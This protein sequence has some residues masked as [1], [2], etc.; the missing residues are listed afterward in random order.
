MNLQVIPYNAQ[1]ELSPR[2]LVI[3]G[4]TG[5]HRKD[6]EKH[7]EEL[8]KHGIPVPDSVPSFYLLSPDLITFEQ[9]ITVSSPYTS[10]EVEPV[11]ICSEGR[12]YLTVGSDHTD[13]NLERESI[14]AS[15]ASC[16]K[17]LASQ[18]WLYED[19]A[20][21]SDEISIH[22]WVYLEGKK[23]PY[24]Q[25]KLSSLLPI[26]EIVSEL[27]KKLAAKLVNAVVFLGTIPL[28]SGK[29]IMGE[30]YDMEMV[31]PTGEKIQLSY[32]VVVDGK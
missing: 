2:L 32:S 7:I 19:L 27:E 14:E 25:G 6:V 31:R 1:L 4:F 30:R 12:W 26:P 24:Q 15:K 5:R 16:P 20:G 3:A 8:R 11:L 28:L 18:A 13:R 17:I 23:L 9:V 10:G 22:S 29:F 21:E